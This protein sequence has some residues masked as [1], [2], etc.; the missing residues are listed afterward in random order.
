MKKY[1]W[2]D[3][4]DRIKQQA[5]VKDMT[6]EEATK[7]FIGIGHSKYSAVRL[8]EQFCKETAK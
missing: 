7:H 8:A 3:A 4:T 1:T 6:V 2:D 5:S